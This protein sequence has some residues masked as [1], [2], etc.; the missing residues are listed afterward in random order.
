MHTL[1]HHVC[2]SILRFIITLAAAFVLGAVSACLLSGCNAIGGAAAGAASGAWRDIKAGSR[3]AADV[4][5][6]DQ[7][8]DQ[9]GGAQ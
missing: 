4:I 2:K 9:K 1:S 3:M 8:S 6:R 5:H 7:E